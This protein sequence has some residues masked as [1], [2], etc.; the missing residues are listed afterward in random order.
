M[1]NYTFTQEYNGTTYNCTAD[2]SGT[3]FF[4]Q[5]IS[6]EG[7]GS[8]KDL[9][10]YGENPPLRPISEMQKVASGIAVGIVMEYI[11]KNGA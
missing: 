8:K 2:V 4:K 10:K 5:S 9:S 3:S 7:I 1:D 11:R 6:I